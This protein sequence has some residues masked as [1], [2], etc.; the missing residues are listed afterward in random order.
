MNKPASTT[1]AS[2]IT[3]KGLVQGVG[4]RPYVYRLA[5]RMG[6][7]GWVENRTDGVLILLQENGVLFR[8]LLK[9]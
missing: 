6:Y 8:S 3:V 4:F 5:T 9:R 7:H 2:L 1:P